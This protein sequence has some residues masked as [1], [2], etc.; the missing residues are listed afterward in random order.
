MVNCYTTLRQ[1][2]PKHFVFKEPPTQLY[3]N[4]NEVKIFM[5]YSCI[6][7]KKKI[8]S[9]PVENISQRMTQMSFYLSEALV[10]P[11]SGAAAFIRKCTTN[12]WIKVFPDAHPCHMPAERSRGIEMW[13]YLKES[14][15]QM[16]MFTAQKGN[17]EDIIAQIKR[18]TTRM[19]I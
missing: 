19:A 6:F 2:Y 14:S 7:Q 8:K 18:F 10:A 13:S 16:K 11:I 3:T 4:S 9:H 1:F 12:I 15:E 17:F 5:R